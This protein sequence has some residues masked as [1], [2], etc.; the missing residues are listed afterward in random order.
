MGKRNEGGKVL[1]SSQMRERWFFLTHTD[2][3]P[4]LSGDG[5]SRQAD[6]KCFQ[7]DIVLQRVGPR[8][9]GAE[10]EC[11]KGTGGLEFRLSSHPHPRPRRVCLTP[12]GCC[13]PSLSSWLVA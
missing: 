7:T 8:G 1:P 12:Q 2:R 5:A 9:A 6:L 13:V 10:P 4:G 11:G 3:F